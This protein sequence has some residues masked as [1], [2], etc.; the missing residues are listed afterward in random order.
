MSRHLIMG[1]CLA[2][3]NTTEHHMFF[4][5]SGKQPAHP[6]SFTR[7]LH[8][9]APAPAPASHQQSHCE[10]LLLASSFG[11]QTP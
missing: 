7:S 4:T 5:V 1:H 2:L 3:P 9:P 6:C 10:D 8:H 11:K